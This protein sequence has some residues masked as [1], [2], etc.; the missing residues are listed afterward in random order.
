MKVLLFINWPGNEENS[1]QIKDV[2]ITVTKVKAR[3]RLL[4]MNDLLFG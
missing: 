3:K 4:T 1:P 2:K